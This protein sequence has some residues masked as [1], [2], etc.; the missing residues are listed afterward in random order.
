MEPKL[1]AGLWVKA[2]VRTCDVA[3]IP[4]AI[5]RKGDA[6]A[7]AILLK[8]SRMDGT[9]Q[10]LSQTRDLDGRRTWMRATGAEPV[11]EADADTYI[12]RQVSRDRDVWVIEIE[13]AQ[14]RYEPDAP[15]V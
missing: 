8:L 2:Q 1:K 14:G 12:E 13:D 6:D 7:G 3:M 15:V 9:C 11:P 10:V 5:L 4:I